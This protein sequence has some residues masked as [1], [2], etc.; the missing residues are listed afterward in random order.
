M[1]FKNG[2]WYITSNQRYI[3][4]RKKAIDL[5]NALECNKFQKRNVN[6]LRFSTIQWNIIHTIKS[7]LKLYVN[8]FSIKLSDFIEINEPIEWGG[9]IIKK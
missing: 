8:Q 7:I 6:S 4:H 1:R 3:F 2:K 5:I 9:C